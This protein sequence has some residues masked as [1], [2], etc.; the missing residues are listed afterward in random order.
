M[1]AQVSR[2]R[3]ALL[4]AD[5]A[6]LNMRAPSAPT[7]RRHMGYAAVNVPSAHEGNCIRVWRLRLRN[8]VPVLDV[9]RRLN[10]SFAGKFEVHVGWTL[11]ENYCLRKC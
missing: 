6:V 8:G 5:Q 9:L 10:A 2:C 4:V 7:G 3:I 11:K 1:Y